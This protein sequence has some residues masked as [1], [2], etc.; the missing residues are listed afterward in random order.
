MYFGN[1]PEITQNLFW[2]CWV[3]LKLSP[4]LNHA[5]VVSHPIYWKKLELSN[6][7]LKKEKRQF[8]ANSN[9]SRVTI[10]NLERHERS[11]VKYTTRSIRHFQKRCSN[12]SKRNGAVELRNSITPLSSSYLN[13]YSTK[14]CPLELFQAVVANNKCHMYVIFTFSQ[15]DDPYCKR[16]RITQKHKEWLVVAHYRVDWVD[17]HGST[18][19][20]TK[21]RNSA[22]TIIAFTHHQIG[23][24]QW[25]KNENILTSGSEVN[26]F[27]GWMEMLRKACRFF[28]QGF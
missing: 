6:S 7:F 3:V 20:W 11:H 22:P 26:C 28:D 12:F 24:R 21:R 23:V 1:L 14:R 15:T 27:K 2:R 19:R 25:K 10:K 18:Q 8:N 13:P 4:Y 5:S 9:L 16:N 17:K